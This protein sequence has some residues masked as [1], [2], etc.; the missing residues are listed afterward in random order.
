MSKSEK[1][2]SQEKS[3]HVRRWMLTKHCIYCEIIT[4]NIES[5]HCTPKTDSVLCVDYTSKKNIIRD[6]SVSLVVKNPPSSPGDM[7]SI[8]GRGTKIPHAAGKLSQWTATEEPASHNKNPAQPK[9]KN[10]IKKNIIPKKKLKKII[11]LKT[12]L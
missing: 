4:P 12:P 5:L 1:V 11:S 3:N 7:S 9:E 8:P 2:S 10:Y 6:F